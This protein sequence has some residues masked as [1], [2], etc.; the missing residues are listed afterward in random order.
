M[1]CPLSCT[2]RAVAGRR[3]KK[4]RRVNN[5]YRCMDGMVRTWQEEADW[6][7]IIGFNHVRPIADG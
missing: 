3:Y 5:E 7:G 6:L 4:Y 2:I 1:I